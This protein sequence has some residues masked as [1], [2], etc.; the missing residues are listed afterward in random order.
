L[1]LYQEKPENR[2]MV[3]T[4]SGYFEHAGGHI[5]NR[6]RATEHVVIYCIKGAGWIFIDGTRTAIVPGDLIV[7]PLG[8]PHSYGA[9]P[10]DPWTIYWFHALGAVVASIAAAM[11]LAE[12][13]PRVMVGLNS[14][15]I[16]LFESLAAVSR[17]GISVETVGLAAAMGEHALRL[18][19]VATRKIGVPVSNSRLQALAQHLSDNFDKPMSLD[20][21]ARRC[22]MSR[23]YFCRAFKAMFGQSPVEY[24][25]G[26]RMKEA[27]RRIQETDERLGN[28]ALAVGFSDYA[29]FSKRFTLFAG[30]S[31]REFRSGIS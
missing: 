12:N 18:G 15:L 10:N 28:I 13:R 27:A 31:P 2:I 7:F 14:R 4:R 20:S 30:V 23:Y 8:I 11:S 3:V 25:L 17:E 19:L 26:V 6:K 21:M 24:H 5:A 9:D 1:A 22:F 16:E 29:Y